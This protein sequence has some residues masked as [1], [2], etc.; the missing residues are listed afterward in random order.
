MDD[1]PQQ[2]EPK[3][4][5]VEIVAIG[6][7][8]VMLDLIDLIP[9]AGDVTDIVAAPMG[10]YYWMKG[11][12]GTAFIAAEVLDLI[13]FVQMVPSRTIGWVI[14]AYI[15]RSPKLQ[16]KLAPALAV[17]GAL[18]GD[19]A[20]GAGAAT[21]ETGELAATTPSA[22]TAAGT[23]PAEAGEIGGAAGESGQ[24]AGAGAWTSR[25][26]HDRE[27]GGGGDSEAERNARPSET[28]TE[29]EAIKQQEET[30]EQGNIIGDEGGAGEL[31]QESG[32]GAADAQNPTAEDRRKQAAEEEY[33][34]YEPEASKNPMDIVKKKELGAEVSVTKPEEESGE[35][36][37][38]KKKLDERFAEIQAKLQK[39]KEVSEG[40]KK[41][42]QSQ[43]DTTEENDFNDG[44]ASENINSSNLPQ[45]KAA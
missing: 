23:V 17:A 4:S 10:M 5:D 2:P 6:V 21:T 27:S 38:A 35:E 26:A 1:E 15:D 28:T 37:P 40:L 12:N 20:E 14:T 33:K 34:K 44:D 8:F 25:E 7:F 30:R 24:T 29:R 36:T 19:V 43:S 32:V 39:E 16:T 11:I 22:G 41:L 9:I 42:K 18:E 31:G 13:P 3:I 45:S